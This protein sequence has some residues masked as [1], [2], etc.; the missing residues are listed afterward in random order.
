MVN[1]VGRSKRREK[2]EEGMLVT[3]RAVLASRCTVLAGVGGR[4]VVPIVTRVP[5]PH[6]GRRCAGGS[7]RRR[8]TH[9]RCRPKSA[10][11]PLLRLRLLLPQ[12]PLVVLLH[13]PDVV[14]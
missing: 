14:S 6:A 1:A 10:S 5:A 11:W 3:L 12:L 8:E 7:V 4:Q 9:I 2:L 13:A